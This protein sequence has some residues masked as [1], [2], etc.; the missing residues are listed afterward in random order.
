[1]VAVRASYTGLKEV[2]THHK[3]K[4]EA[5]CIRQQTLSS[6]QKKK[7]IQGWLVTK[8]RIQRQGSRTKSGSGN[9]YLPRSNPGLIIG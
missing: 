4:V 9:P 2:I 5:A 7:V 3:Y 8:T 1:M 6:C